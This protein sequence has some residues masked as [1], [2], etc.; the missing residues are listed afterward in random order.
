MSKLKFRREIND[1]N[2]KHLHDN[3]VKS[4]CRGTILTLSRVR[5]FARRTRDYCRAYLRLEKVE[6][7]TSKDS[8]EKMGRHAKLTVT[9]STW[10]LASLTRNEH[11]FLSCCTN[12]TEVSEVVCGHRRVCVGFV[13]FFFLCVRFFVFLVHVRVRVGVGVRSSRHRRWCTS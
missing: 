8:I 4:M 5:R 6:N 11:V 10:S 7:G 3:I 9:K 12:D 2:P 13:S 1:E